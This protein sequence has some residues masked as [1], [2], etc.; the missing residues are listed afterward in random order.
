MP[1][2]AAIPERLVAGPRIRRYVSVY[3]SE[4]RVPANSDGITSLVFVRQSCNCS[5]RSLAIASALSDGSPASRLLPRSGRPPG[6]RVPARAAVP[7]TAGRRLDPGRY[8]RYPA[9]DPIADDRVILDVAVFL[10]ANRPNRVERI[11]IGLRGIDLGA[12]LGVGRPGIQQMRA[13]DIPCRGRR[14]FPRRAI[15][16]AS[17]PGRHR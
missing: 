5:A 12:H 4:M 15:P 11:V 9:A 2:S 10:R 16:A 8:R 17:V 1:R 13:C 6:R 7:W 3:R 14:E